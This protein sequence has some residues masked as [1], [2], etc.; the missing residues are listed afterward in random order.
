MIQENIEERFKVSDIFALL[1]GGYDGTKSRHRLFRLN[2]RIGILIGYD[3]GPGIQ[4]LKD[5]IPVG[6]KHGTYG[7]AHGNLF[8]NR[9]E[10]ARV[11]DSVTWSGGGMG[12]SISDPTIIRMKGSTIE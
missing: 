1:T 4:S 2:E 9:V 5:G 8:D 7:I 10:S 6:Q 11:H 12:T 3:E